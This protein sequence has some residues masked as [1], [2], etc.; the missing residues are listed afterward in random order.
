MQ[1]KAS[2]EQTHDLGIGTR[3]LRAFR[4][5]A[6]RRSPRLPS[7][8]SKTTPCKVA[9]GRRNQRFGP[10]LDMSGKSAALLHHPNIR[11]TVSRATLMRSCSAWPD[12]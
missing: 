5:V 11:W 12:R 1:I 3:S 8:I 9:G 2:R 7:K 10:K 6:L 4:T